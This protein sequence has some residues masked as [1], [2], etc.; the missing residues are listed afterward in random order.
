MHGNANYTSCGGA[1]PIEIFQ[2]MS[3]KLEFR[4]QDRF[5]DNEIPRNSSSVEVWAPAIKDGRL[6]GMNSEASEG[7]NL[8][9]YGYSHD[10]ISG[11]L[12][13][14]TDKPTDIQH[15][16]YFRISCPGFILCQAVHSDQNTVIIDNKVVRLRFRIPG[17]ADNLEY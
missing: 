3:F 5:D 11:K 8:Q 4:V 13:M 7:T 16:V 10:E 17:M 14:D 12:L 6:I 15:Q 2:F 9:N 1:I